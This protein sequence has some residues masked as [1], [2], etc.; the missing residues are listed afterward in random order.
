LTTKK[1]FKEIFNAPLA[2]FPS[3]GMEKNFLSNPT[4]KVPS[5]KGVHQLFMGIRV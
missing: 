5:Y 2:A 4:E 3:L 1:G